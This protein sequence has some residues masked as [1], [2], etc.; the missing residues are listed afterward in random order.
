MGLYPGSLISKNDKWLKASQ[1]TLN[2][3]GDKSTGWATAHRL[4][5][6]ARTKNVKRTMDLVKSFIINNVL[7]NLWD[8]HPPF[9]ID[10]NFGYVA[11][12]NEMFLQSHNGYIELLPCLPKKWGKGSIKGLKSRGGFAIDMEFSKNNFKATIKS[13]CGQRLRL[14]NKGYSYRINQEKLLDSTEEYINIDTN[15]GDVIEVVR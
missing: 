2:L 10:G 13:E 8:S 12:I 15:I 9:Q 14:L 11:G 5:L 7:N 3:R 6:W 4:C 1:V